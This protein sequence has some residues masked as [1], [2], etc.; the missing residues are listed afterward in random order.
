MTSWAFNPH[1]GGITISPTLKRDIAER[2]EKHAASNYKGLY[3]RIDIRFRGVLCYIDAYKEPKPPDKKL[4]E[5]NHESMEAYTERM[6]NFPIH[7]GRIRHFGDD[8]W[9]YA[10]YT[11][12]NERYEPA[13]FLNGEWFGTPE[14]AFDIGARYLVDE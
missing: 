7:I 10:F 1:S 12:S 2:L 9:S 11:Y 14:E 6:R 3:F 5:I 13:T 4:L 8:R